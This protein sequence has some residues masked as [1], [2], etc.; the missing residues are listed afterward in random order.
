VKISVVTV[1]F[2]SEKTI[3]DTIK[4][5]ESQTYPDVEHIIIDGFSSDNTMEIVKAAPH[6]S[7]YISE[8]D[9]GIY[10]AMNKGINLA[11]GDVIGTLNS[12]DFYLD[13]N[14]LSKVADVF[15]SQPDI[16]AIYADLVYVEQDNT[17]KVVRFWKSHDF[18]LGMFRNGWVP[19]HP[20]FFVRK[21]VYQKHGVFNLKYKIAADFELMYRFL[22]EKKVSVHYLPEL[23]IKM[24]VGGKTNESLANILEQNREIL[25]VMKTREKQF[26]SI[27]WLLRKVFNRVLQYIRR[28]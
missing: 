24:R 9:N 17:D 15:K 4:S 19:A 2:N 23:L 7:T 26:S 5:V 11:T 12:D 1:C 14:V 20:T 3:T 6:I 18:Y 25:S 10:D 22:E 28:P 27:T 16:D 21:E 13:K 8:A